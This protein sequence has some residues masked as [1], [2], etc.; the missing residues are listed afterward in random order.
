MLKKLQRQDSIHVDHNQLDPLHHL[1]SYTPILCWFYNHGLP[2][3][4]QI[5]NISIYDFKW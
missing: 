3:Q 4:P 1:K 2:V 5:H